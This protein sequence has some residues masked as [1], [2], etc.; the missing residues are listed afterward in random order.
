MDGIVFSFGLF[1]TPIQEEFLSSKA[2]VA[3]IGSLLSGF[4]LIVGPFVSGLANKF[5]FR[6]VTIFGSIIAASAFALS[7]LAQSV[8]FLHLLYGVFGGIGFCF[9]YMPSV[10]IV[11]YYFEK[12]RP[13]ATGIALCGSGVGT[14]VMGPF[15]KYLVETVGWR[16]ALLVQAGMILTCSFFALAYR[17]I[18]PTIVTDMK[19]EDE[20]LEKKSLT[21][22]VLPLPGFKA[23]TEGRFAYSMPNSVVFEKLIGLKL[24]LKNYFLAQYVDG[25]CT[26]YQL[27]YRCGSFQVIAFNIKLISFFN[28]FHYR[29]SGAN[30]DRR[31]SQPGTPIT[32]NQ[33]NISST[34]KK[35]EQFKQAQKRSGHVTPTEDHP[36]PPPILSHEL[37]PV[38]ETEETEENEG[39]TL[40]EKNEVKAVIVSS[41]RRHT[42]SGK[43]GL[44]SNTNS[45]RGSRQ[46]VSRPMYR[47]DILYSGSLAKLPQYRSQTSLGYHMSVTHIPTRNDI[48]EEV[49]GEGKCKICPEAVSRVISTMLDISLLKN[50][51]FI[52]LAFSGFFTMMG[53][54][55][56]F[57]YISDRAK[58]GGIDP[59]TAVFLISAIGLFNTIARI[60]CGWLSSLPGVSALLLNNIFIT[61]GGL[62]TIFSGMFMEVY[63]Q[64][65]YTLIFGVTCAAFSALR[66]IIVVDLLGLEKLTNAFGIILLFQ[67][68]KK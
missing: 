49:E 2:T 67:G 65:I 3:L 14:F 53:F 39:L 20:I 64:Y 60:G 5:G 7:Y 45:R 19:D 22:D 36:H 44:D 4:Y 43:R 1:I 48:E 15:S 10:I 54:F 55:V 62:A 57:I 63:A 32:L 21:G 13:L 52:L 18:E 29:G 50:Y 41:G 35:L 58:L 28:F 66:S 12:W 51:S 11:G 34:T 24:K 26:K 8:T 68:K 37:G 59:E 27:P 31:P 40:L 61:L 23:F 30:L 42:I 17:P 47:D 6:L 56:P 38:G 16:N 33:I 25:N 46:D 9:I